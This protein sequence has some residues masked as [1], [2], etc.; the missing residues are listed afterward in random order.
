VVRPPVMVAHGCDDGR[1]KKCL[2]HL[3]STVSTGSFLFLVSLPAHYPPLLDVRVF[4]GARGKFLDDRHWS[5][6]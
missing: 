2:P 4:S 6:S 1:C 5:S 3:P